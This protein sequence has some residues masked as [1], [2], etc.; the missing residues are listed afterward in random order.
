MSMTLMMMVMMMMMMKM[1]MT[2]I[3][4][5]EVQCFA[6][7]RQCSSCWWEG[8]AARRSLTGRREK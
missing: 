4:D 1:M 2:N 3:G 5:T 6:G 7:R 8:S